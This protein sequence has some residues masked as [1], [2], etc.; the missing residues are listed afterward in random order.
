MDCYLNHVPG[1][2][3]LNHMSN[4]LRKLHNES[5]LNNESKLKKDKPFIKNEHVFI[6]PGNKKKKG[7]GK[8]Y[9]PSD[10]FDF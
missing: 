8:W 2:E 9:Y 7:R 5:K 3:D 10:E 6:N 1:L 4:K